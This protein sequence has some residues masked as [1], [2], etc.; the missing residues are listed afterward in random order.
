MFS[1]II[2]L[3]ELFH[4]EAAKLISLDKSLFNYDINNKI[5]RICG[6]IDSEVENFGVEKTKIAK[7]IVENIVFSSFDAVF[8]KYGFP[9]AKDIIANLPLQAQFKQNTFL[10][11]RFTM[12]D[13]THYAINANSHN[14]IRRAIEE[15]NCELGTN[16]NDNLFLPDLEFEENLI[17]NIETPNRNYDK[18]LGKIFIKSLN[19]AANHHYDNPEEFIEKFKYYVKSPE[20]GGIDNSKYKVFYNKVLNK[21]V[22]E[23]ARRGKFLLNIYAEK[24]EDK[25]N[26]NVNFAIT[27]INNVLT[28]NNIDLSH[29][30]IVEDDIQASIRMFIKLVARKLENFNILDVDVKSI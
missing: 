23:F 30:K 19:K 6:K 7:Y 2:K 13:L 5:L 17:A 20:Y 21:I 25:E 12:H 1:N 18:G 24:H 10:Y 3:A 14:E 27:I 29:H 26:L 22:A 28:D 11:V 15:G 9:K 16:A 4:K 8:G